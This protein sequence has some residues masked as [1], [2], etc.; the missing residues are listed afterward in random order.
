MVCVVCGSL[1][2]KNDTY[3]LFIEQDIDRDEDATVPE[4]PLPVNRPKIPNAD[5]IGVS[6]NQYRNN[7]VMGRAI[8]GYV[9]LAPLGVGAYVEMV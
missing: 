6:N 8:A 3:P 9:F 5:I 2:E 1:T 7:M 4:R